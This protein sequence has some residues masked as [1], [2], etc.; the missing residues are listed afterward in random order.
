MQQQTESEAATRYC[1]ENEISVLHGGCILM[2][3]EN[4]AFY[5]KMHRWFRVV[6]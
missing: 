4:T 2:H 6:A 1:Q 3:A 5:Y